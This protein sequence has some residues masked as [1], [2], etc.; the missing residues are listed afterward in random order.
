MAFLDADEDGLYVHYMTPRKGRLPAESFVLSLPY[1]GGVTAGVEL[2]AERTP[3]GRWRPLFAC[4]PAEDNQSIPDSIRLALAE[5]LSALMWHIFPARE[6]G[7]A[8]RPVVTSW[9][10][11]KLNVAAC[12]DDRYGLPHLPFSLQVARMEDPT[13]SPADSHDAARRICPWPDPETW[14]FCRNMLRTVPI[15]QRPVLL[16]WSPPEDWFRRQ[17]VLCAIDEQ[18]KKDTRREHA[19]RDRLRAALM[20]FEYS[21]YIRRLRTMRMCFHLAGVETKAVM[22]DVEATAHRI[23]KL[24]LDPGR[25]ESW[26]ATACISSDIPAAVLTEHTAHTQTAPAGEPAASIALYSHIPGIA[27]P[28]AASAVIAFPGKPCVVLTAWLNPSAD[29]GEAL[30]HATSLLI[31]ECVKRGV[32]NILAA[33]ELQPVRISPDSGSLVPAVPDHWPTGPGPHSGAAPH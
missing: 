29:I 14:G 18:I 8:V 27:P 30:Q 7:R 4:L 5:D 6:R 9:E 19:H 2:V 31:E 12:L 10:S 26:T 13:G 22:V 23:R 25:Q 21:R 1:M 11:G 32:R 28:D 15:G 20:S 16:Y 17:D 33:R 3:R 24:G